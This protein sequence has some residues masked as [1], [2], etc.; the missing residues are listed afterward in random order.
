M[1]WDKRFF[2]F[3]LL[4]F[5]FILIVSS[6]DVAVKALNTY[7][8]AT[9]VKSGNISQTTKAS[10]NPSSP[11][12][13]GVGE[14]L[15]ANRKQKELYKEQLAN[16]ENS[17]QRGRQED[18]MYI[19]NGTDLTIDNIENICENCNYIL[20]GYLMEEDL[21]YTKPIS[22]LPKKEVNSYLFSNMRFDKAQHYEMLKKSGKALFPYFKN[23]VNKLSW[24]SDLYWSGIIDDGFLDGE[25]FGYVKIPVQSSYEDDFLFVVFQ[26]TFSGGYPVG[27]LDLRIGENN[28]TYARFEYNQFKNSRYNSTSTV[29]NKLV[30]AISEYKNSN[31]NNKPLPYK[32]LSIISHAPSNGLCLFKENLYDGY[33][34]ISSVFQKS[35]TSLLSKAKYGY[36]N[37]DG[38]IVIN[39]T[40]DKAS[41][42]MYGR[43]EVALPYFEKEFTYKGR[44]VDENLVNDLDYINRYHPD[45]IGAG[46]YVDSNQPSDIIVAF[47]ID[48]QGLFI[49]FTEN[50]KSFFDARVTSIKEK[51]EQERLTQLKHE[52]ERQKEYAE[53]EAR[54]NKKATPLKTIARRVANG[55]AQHC[56]GKIVDED[57]SDLYER[58][59]IDVK[60]L[61]YNIPSLD[62][63]LPGA[64]FKNMWVEYAITYKSWKYKNFIIV[65][66]QYQRNSVIHIYV[67]PNVDTFLKNH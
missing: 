46:K 6:C 29:Y 52:R 13:I 24:Q 66:S 14:A 39:P 26:G 36:Y 21:G 15:L 37:C 54:I 23:G 34:A 60:P 62:V 4:L 67:Y 9:Q 64:V 44:R 22:F 33:S 56:E 30:D 3:Y 20:D 25:G 27:R 45:H 19:S 28:Y 12:I 2:S 48:K 35:S 59:E 57:Y 55:I 5:V 40:F 61:S 51:D 49:D 8:L 47:Y 58:Y 41:D 18:R 7:N 53:E 17:I 32:T 16:F 42:F 11:T 10:I 43:A 65:T 1:C 50:Q 31:K 63:I 38:D